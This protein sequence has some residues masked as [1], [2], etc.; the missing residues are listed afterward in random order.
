MAFVQDRD[1]YLNC[2]FFI[3]SWKGESTKLELPQKHS[4]YLK[5][6]ESPYPESESEIV[7]KNVPLPYKRHQPQP[8]AHS[9]QIRLDCFP[10]VPWPRYDFEVGL[11]DEAGVRVVAIVNHVAVSHRKGVNSVSQLSNRDS[12][13]AQKKRISGSVCSPCCSS[14][15]CLTPALISFWVCFSFILIRCMPG[16]DVLC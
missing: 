16:G 5:S 1:G 11:Q 13:N 3:P 2:Y 14:W 6:V 9:P 10:S 12:S 7:E 4:P 15:F 8:I